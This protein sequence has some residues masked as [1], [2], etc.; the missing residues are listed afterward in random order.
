MLNEGARRGSLWDASLMELNSE[1]GGE[2]S[3]G[4]TTES[5]F[6]F[7]L[8]PWMSAADWKWNLVC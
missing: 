1:R 8:S 6:F 5:S 3:T 2:R 4:R 7:M